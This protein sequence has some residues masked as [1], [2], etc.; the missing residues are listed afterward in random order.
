MVRAAGLPGVPL[1]KCSCKLLGLRTE[2]VMCE[3]LAESRT[4]YIDFSCL[5]ALPTK[6]HEMLYTHGSNL[7]HTTLDFRLRSSREKRKLEKDG[8]ILRQLADPG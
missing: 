7:T 5:Q 6:L 2:V 4:R 8:P 1:R 3:S